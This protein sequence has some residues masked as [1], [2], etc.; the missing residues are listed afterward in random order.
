MSELTAALVAAVAPRLRALAGAG[1]PPVVVATGTC[2]RSRALATPDAAP[3][4]TLVLSSSS[5]D[6]AAA[7][8][9]QARISAADAGGV[10]NR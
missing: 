5:P 1:G 9:T 4:G 10:S 3:A 7:L 8:S 2:E 6:A